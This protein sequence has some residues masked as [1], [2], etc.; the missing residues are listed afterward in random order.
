MC[1]ESCDGPELAGDWDRFRRP[2]GRLERVRLALPGDR[3]ATGVAGVADEGDGIIGRTTPATSTATSQKDSWVSLKFSPA[4][5]PG[6]LSAPE[7]G[8]GVRG[9]RAGGDSCGAGGAGGV[10]GVD[11]VRPRMVTFPK[12]APD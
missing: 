3:M 7:G 4:T 1:D 12:G 10:G 9:G 6:W 11:R 8:G 2:D 5:E